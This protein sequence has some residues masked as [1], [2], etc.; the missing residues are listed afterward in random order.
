MKPRLKLHL[1]DSAIDKYFATVLLALALLFTPLAQATPS[2]A[3]AH[4]IGSAPAGLVAAIT[5][6]QAQEAAKNPAYAIGRNGC[7]QLGERNNTPA[8]AGC[9]GKQGPIFSAGRQT[10]RLQLTTWGRAGQLRP[11]TLTRTAP[12]T[13]HIAYRG[14]HISEWWRV[15]PLGYEQGFTIKQAPTGH[16]PVVLQ[17]STNRAP[18]IVHGML[19]WGTLRYGKLHVT[20]AAGHVLPATLSAHGK[21]ITLALDAAHAR[22]PI[23]IDPI[24]WV[25]QEVTANNDAANDW[26]GSLVTLS[27]NGTIQQGAAHVFTTTNN[28]ST[29]TQFLSQRTLTNAG[30]TA[31]RPVTVTLKATGA[32]SSTI[33]KSGQLVNGSPD[34]AQTVNTTIVPP[35]PTVSG[36]SSNTALLPNANITDTSDCTLTHPAT[37]AEAPP[38]P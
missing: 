5:R 10:L 23:R 13:N 37:R 32:A 36:S 15:L 2:T 3:V 16:G 34:L 9:F 28:W 33:T 26:F 30:T 4:N 7:A 38:W 29:N 22:Y 27:A 35:P 8:L 24:V 6:T 21:T 11:V 1:P 17:L 12:E 14:Q 25:Q 20:D 19:A 31:S 18:R